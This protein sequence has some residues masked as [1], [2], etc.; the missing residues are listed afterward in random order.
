MHPERLRALILLTTA[1]SQR[2][3]PLDLFAGLGRENWE[4]LLWSRLA[5]G[6]SSREAESRIEHT[7]QMMT[8]EDAVIRWQGSAPSDVSALLP[9]IQTPTL[10]IHPRD[11]IHLK[12]EEAVRLASGLP[13]ARLTMLESDDPGDLHGRPASAL[14]AIDDFF[15][16]L[17]TEDEHVALEESRPRRV[18]L[19]ARQTEVLALLVKGKT[20]REIATDLVLS[21]RTVERHVEE[22]YAKLDVRNRA[23]AIALALGPLA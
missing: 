9:T 4:L 8:R 11:F 15:A 18:K 3:W 7:R 21:L 14:A 12:A 17:S 10:V 23:E 19:S 20:N 16:G 5:P 6:L 13:N 2:A 1:V 22:L